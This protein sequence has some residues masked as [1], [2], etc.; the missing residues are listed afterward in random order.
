MP[1]IFLTTFVAAP[2]AVCFNL[3]RSMELHQKSTAH[4]SEKAV[5]GTTTGLLQLGEWVTWE[6]VHFGIRQQLTSRITQFHFPN[7]FRDEQ[8]KGA[9]KYFK[10]DH[11]FTA[12]AGGTEMRDVFKFESPLGILGRI[13]NRLVLTNYMKKLLCQRNEFIKTVTSSQEWKAFLPANE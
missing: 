3:S 1:F 4:T 12:V 10:H 11:Y 8:I 13:F 2:P 9:F 7:H 5:A 6:A